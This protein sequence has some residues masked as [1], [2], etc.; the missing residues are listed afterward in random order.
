MPPGPPLSIGGLLL[1]ITKLH[2][3]LS[4]WDCLTMAIDLR[5]ENR[6]SRGL[7]YTL[8]LDTGGGQVQLRPASGVEPAGSLAP[9]Q[10]AVG[11]LTYETPV[12]PDTP[13][14][15]TNCLYPSLLSIH[16]GDRA[17]YLV[18]TYEQYGLG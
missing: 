14:Q 12:T 7:A 2:P 13:V 8:R 9:D 17:A 6:M 3:S 18:L 11:R 5:L 4:A 16:A 15:P 1:S 10:V